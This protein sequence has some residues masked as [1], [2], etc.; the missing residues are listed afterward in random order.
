MAGGR[1]REVAEKRL[2]LVVYG[3]MKPGKPLDRTFC[4]VFTL[5]GYDLDTLFNAS[6]VYSAVHFNL[7]YELR[8][9]TAVQGT[10]ITALE[11]RVCPET[12]K[13]FS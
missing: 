13:T 7:L 12:W 5:L 11:R 2:L 3:H 4:E 9:A 6:P 1:L 10:A 8:I